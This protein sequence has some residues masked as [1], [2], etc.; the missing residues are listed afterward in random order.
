M[1]L[2][3]REIP[4]SWREM[5]VQEGDED[6]KEEVSLLKRETWHVCD[7]TIFTFVIFLLSRD[8]KHH[9]DKSLDL[10]SIPTKNSI[11]QHSILFLKYNS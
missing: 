10:Q 9:G 3:K 4:T 1:R 6:Q 8:L 2:K 5:N 11:F 7:C